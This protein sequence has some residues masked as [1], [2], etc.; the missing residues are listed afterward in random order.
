V[1]KGNLPITKVRVYFGN[2]HHAQAIVTYAQ[3]FMYR[4]RR[5]L[6]RSAANA[7]MDSTWLTMASAARYSRKAAQSINML[8]F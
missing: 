3:V 2:V 6:Y 8:L 1:V 7:R 5:V 4:L